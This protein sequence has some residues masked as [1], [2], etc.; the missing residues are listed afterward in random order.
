[1]LRGSSFLLERSVR[2]LVPLIKLISE[3]DKRIWLIDVNNYSDENIDLIIKCK[4]DLA[5]VLRA[6]KDVSD[7]LTTKIMLGIFGNVPAFDSYFKQGFN[8]SYCKE[9]QLRKIRDFY[10]EHKL[11][12]NQENKK[13]KTFDFLTG[14]ETG[15]NYTNAK[16]IDMIGFIK[17]Q[18]KKNL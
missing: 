17:G 15:R 12:I 6:N 1:M 13:I 14:E 18:N 5:L 11:I 16:I 2:Y 9:N 4:K 3:Y 8:V 7:I 10:E